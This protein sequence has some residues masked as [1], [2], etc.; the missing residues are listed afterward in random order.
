MPPTL[1]I[2]MVRMY[3]KTWKVLLFSSFFPSYGNDDRGKVGQVLLP[4]LPLSPPL[5]AKRFSGF[6]REAT[7]GWG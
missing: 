6:A 2:I 3:G 7:L 4:S 5:T 1:L